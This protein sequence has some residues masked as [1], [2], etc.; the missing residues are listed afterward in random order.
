MKNENDKFNSV[1]KKMIINDFGF[2]QEE[3]IKLL[4]KHFLDLSIF[5]SSS[6]SILIIKTSNYSISIIT[7]IIIIALT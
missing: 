6:S 2:T 7:T 1:Y 3:N 4:K 5:Y